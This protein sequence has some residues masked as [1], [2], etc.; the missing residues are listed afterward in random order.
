MVRVNKA[1]EPDELRSVLDACKRLRPSLVYLCGVGEPLLFRGVVDVVR[2]LS[3]EVGCPV[4]I[5]TNGQLL[6]P[7]V[8]ERLIEAGI[9]LVNVSI[10]GVSDE[11]Y[12]EHM[13]HCSLERVHANIE[14]ALEIKPETISLQGVITQKN[15]HE[16]PELVRY[17]T[18]RGVKIFTFNQCSNKSGFL[19]DHDKLWVGDLSGLYQE[20]A[21]H[22]LDSWVS[23]NSCNFAVK[24]QNEFLCRVPM[25]F[26][27]VDVRGNILHCMHD[28]SDVTAYGRFA[29]YEPEALGE[30]MMKRVST[31]LEICQ[32]CNAPKQDVNTVLWNG[33]VVTEKEMFTEV[34]PW[35]IALARAAAERPPGAPDA[36]AAT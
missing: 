4:G 15:Q 36:L 22:R 1:M 35:E 27:S 25:N 12:G 10:N 20:I 7:E 34:A 2:E 21:D 3:Y 17:W 11:T 28:F 26:V 33:Q 19:D 6:T 14:R 5:N 23:V 29:D 32:T 9:S 16:I 30:L 8:Y 13:K 31:K 24:Q 18:G